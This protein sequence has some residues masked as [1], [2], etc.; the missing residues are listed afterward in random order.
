VLPRAASA[1]DF[2]PARGG[3]RLEVVAEATDLNAKISAPTSS[4][5]AKVNWID[6][7]TGKAR[8]VCE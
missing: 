4:L 2:S 6:R 3:D 8:P 1:L 5:P 7:H